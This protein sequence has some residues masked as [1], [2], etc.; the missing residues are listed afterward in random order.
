MII[1]AIVLLFLLCTGIGLS[2][3]A[4]MG[5]APIINIIFMLL[6]AVP[7]P[8]LIVGSLKSTMP[9]LYLVLLGSSIVTLVKYFRV[10]S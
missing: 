9:V 10:R 7:T 1:A 5:G 6:I 3:R 8:Y 4:L 2:Q